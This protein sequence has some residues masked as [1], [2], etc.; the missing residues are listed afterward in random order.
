MAENVWT[1]L[2]KGCLAFA[3]SRAGDLVGESFSDSGSLVKSLF[4][5][6]PAGTAKTRLDELKKDIKDLKPQVEPLVKALKPKIDAG[7][8]AVTNMAKELGTDPFTFEAAGRAATELGYLLIAFDEAV[9]IIAV[10]LA[11]PEPTPAARQ[12]MEDAIRGITAPWKKPFADMAGDVHKTFDSVC[13]TVLGVDNAG[14][15]F[16]D[17]LSWNR[18]EKRLALKL[19]GTG[20]H[21][22]GALSFDGG[23]IEAFFQYKDVAK[24][25]VAINTTLKA[26]LRGDKFLEKIIPAQA[27]TADAKSTA[28]TLD[29]HDGLTFGSGP[30]KRLVLPVRFSLP[31]IEVRELAIARPAKQQADDSGRIDIMTTIAGKIGSAFA[32]VVEEGGVSIFWHDGGA[33][34]VKPKPP[35]GAGLRINVGPVRGGGY[36]RYKELEHGGEYGGVIDLQVVKIGVTAIGLIA[37]DP[38]SMVIV[39]GVHFMPKIEL[40]FGFTLNGVGGLLAIDRRIDTAALTKGMQSGMI[41]NLLFPNDPVASAPT[42]L[43]QLGQ[44]FPAQ[45]GAFVVG[46]MVELGWGSQAGFMKARVGILIALPDPKVILLGAVEIGVPSA[47]VEAKLRIVDLRAEIYGEISPDYLLILVSLQNSKIFKV[48]ISGDIGLF[49]RWAGGSA[50]ALSIGGFFPKYKAPAEL[51]QMRRFTVNVSPPVDWLKVTAEGY[52]A[53][54]SNSVQFGGKVSVKAEVGPASGE[55]WLSLDA[56]FQWSP[57]FYFIV[58]IDAGIRIKAFGATIAGASFHGELS[59]TTPWKLEGHASV[60]IL[61]W[62]VPVDIGPITWGED[63]KTQ[64]PAVSPAQ[65][66]QQALLADEAWK[67]VLPAGADQMVRLRDDPLPLLVHPL[68]AL[69]VKQQRL[70]LETHIDRLGSSPVTSNR[71]FLADASIGSGSLQAVSHATELFSPGHFIKMSDDQQVSRPDFESFPCGMRLAA[72]AAVTHDP[73]PGSIAVDWE[74]C[75]PHEE[76]PRLVE[77][78]SFA[79]LNL[80]LASNRGFLRQSAVAAAARAV[81]NPYAPARINPAATVRTQAAGTVSVARAD[82][83]SLPAGA[84][85]GVPTMVAASWLKANAGA[86]LQIVAAQSLEGA[87]A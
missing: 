80:A 14:G 41:G 28:I 25:G 3:H 55:A 6:S 2:V 10:E 66:V 53:I 31:G 43:D 44:A 83:L 26:G 42:I 62:D 79:E 37:T 5:G 47:D 8:T 46:P 82:D 16:A 23:W 4:D 40:S 1:A 84:P 54:T 18:S 71:A 21:A 36:L 87:L 76:T 72:A 11:K 45:P 77:R 81:G 32:T 58:V 15:K 20:Q 78:F 69:E 59:G 63:D 61:W 65:Q 60:E 85:R 49:V 13:K 22:V 75:Y 48:T 56:L 33:L 12:Q 39:I 73:D 24:L 27:P 74:T 51:S 7:K 30:N 35:S 19:I 57:K 64:L 9:G 86:G 34:E 38:F 70:P 50:F 52:F 17:E 29:T 67:P 68:G